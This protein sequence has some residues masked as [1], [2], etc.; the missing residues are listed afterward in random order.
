MRLVNAF[1]DGPGD[2]L[3]VVREGVLRGNWLAL[4]VFVLLGIGLAALVIRV[5]RTQLAESLRLLTGAPPAAAERAGFAFAVGLLAVNFG[6]RFDP[7]A[8]VLPGILYDLV[9]LILFLG[10]AIYSGV[11]LVRGVRRDGGA[12]SIPG[13][14]FVSYGV[15][16]AILIFC[17]VQQVGIV[18]GADPGAIIGNGNP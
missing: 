8:R 7:L 3:W 16:L 17:I 6:V 13:H 2:D 1:T 4:L 5:G 15:L 11:I 10:T 18:T 14:L 9:F 12:I